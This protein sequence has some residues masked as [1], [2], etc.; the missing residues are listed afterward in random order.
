MLPL[1]GLAVVVFAL[2]VAPLTVAALD[3]RGATSLLD[4][5]RIVPAAAEVPAA[6][7]RFAGAWSG[8]WRDRKGEEAQCTT[9]VVEE[10]HANGYA[11]VVYSVGASPVLGSGMP[12]VWRTTAR[13]ADGVLTTEIVG[14]TF[15]IGRQRLH[16]A[17]GGQLFGAAGDDIDLGRWTITGDHRVCRTWTTWDTGRE[18]CYAPFREGD[19]WTFD[20]SGRFAAFPAQRTP[21]GLAA[22]DR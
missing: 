1:I 13:H 17:A 11:R 21:G 4:D 14:F 20:L 5:V 9:L 7:V 8:A 2:T 16:F 18:R 10:V 19:R 3:C 22:P 12:G 15:T 6:L